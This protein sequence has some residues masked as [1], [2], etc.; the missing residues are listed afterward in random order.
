MRNIIFFFSNFFLLFWLN[1]DEEFLKKVSPNDLY[2]NYKFDVNITMNGV[3]WIYS[4]SYRYCD[5]K[6]LRVSWA[7]FPLNS[8]LENRLI[9]LGTDEVLTNE[10]KIILEMAPNPDDKKKNEKR[11]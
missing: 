4:G 10:E 5:P 9:I 3:D 11:S 8:S 6:V 7:N 2:E 1:N